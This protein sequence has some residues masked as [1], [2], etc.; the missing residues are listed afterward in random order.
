MSLNRILERS[1]ETLRLILHSAASETLNRRSPR[2][3]LTRR[4][5]PTGAPLTPKGTQ[6]SPD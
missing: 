4:R 1:V 5:T 3:P 2:T 6:K